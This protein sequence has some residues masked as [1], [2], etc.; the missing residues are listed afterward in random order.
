MSQHGEG[1]V[2]IPGVVAADLVLVE[3]N[4]AF[5]GLESLLDGPAGT[6]DADQFA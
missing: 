1:D 5:G 3:A 2:S 6:C 4:L